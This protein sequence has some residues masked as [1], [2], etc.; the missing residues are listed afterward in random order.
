MTDMPVF[1]DDDRRGGQALVLMSLAYYISPGEERRKLLKWMDIQATKFEEQK[2]PSGVTGCFRE[3]VEGL[4][5]GECV[6]LLKSAR[7]IDG[8]H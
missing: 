6:E 7:G 2:L 8:L 4:R 1:S 3:F 5:A